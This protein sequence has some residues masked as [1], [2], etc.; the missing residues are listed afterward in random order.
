MR[1]RELAHFGIDGPG[2][3]WGRN[4]DNCGT[5]CLVSNALR[6]KSSDDEAVYAKLSCNASI[7]VQFLPKNNSYSYLIS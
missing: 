1:L 4:D 7:P 6:Y 3:P 2:R 5:A